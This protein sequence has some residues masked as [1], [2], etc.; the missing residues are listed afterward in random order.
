MPTVHSGEV[1][2]Y[3]ETA[4]SG[5]PIVWI[6]GTGLL[7][8][9]Y[10]AQVAALRD[11]Y[12]CVTVDLRGSGQTTGGEDGC[13]VA[14][15][16]ADVAGLIDGLGL[17]PAHV[18][19]FS[20][21]SAVAQELALHRPDL[22]RSAVLLSTWSSTPTEHHIRR[23]F[24][25]RL[26]ALEH[27][28]LDVFAQFAFWM[29]AP[30]VV[31]DEPEL[32]AV[33]EQRL[34]AHTSTRLEGTAGH[35]RT[36]LRHD[37]RDRLS[38]IAC[39]TLVVYG[40]EDLITLPAYNERVAALVPGAVVRRIPRAGHLAVYERPDQLTRCIDEFLATVDTADE[41]RITL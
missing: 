6:P 31:D 41:E 11:R 40:E 27:G 12:R 21:G 14:D 36:D 23:H 33:V 39:P 22:V 30:S 15:L 34:R 16:A 17:G 9:C 38:D 26:Y 28:P 19:G 20:L 29:S 35:F 32:Q 4:G 18:V 24:E 8:A 7:G 5:R 1:D 2:V 25:S 3:Y 37:T 13:S 10:A